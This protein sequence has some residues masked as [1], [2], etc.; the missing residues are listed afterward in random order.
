MKTASLNTVVHGK[1][2]S[3]VV[4]VGVIVGVTSSSWASN[5][6]GRFL[7]RNDPTDYLFRTESAGVFPQT[8]WN[9]IDQGGTTFKGTSQS[10]LDDAGNFTNVKIIYDASD[11]WISDGGT[12]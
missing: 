4:S 5:I 11:A 10:L 3:I 8:Y 7:G 1:L 2:S 9:N 6:G 12:A